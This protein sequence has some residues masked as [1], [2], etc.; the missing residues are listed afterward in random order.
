MGIHLRITLAE[1]AAGCKKTVSS[2]SVAPWKRLQRFHASSRAYT[3]KTLATAA[4][5]PVA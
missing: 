1:A 2:L 5:A 3:A 4:T